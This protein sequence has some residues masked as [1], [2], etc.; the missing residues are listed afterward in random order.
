MGLF[1]ND[2]SSTPTTCPALPSPINDAAPISGSLTFNAMAKY[3]AGI[4]AAVAVVL[5]LGLILLHATHFSRP[6]EQTKIIRIIALIPVYALVSFGVIFLGQNAIYL[7]PWL[8]A[9]E[10]ISIINFFALLRTLSMSTFAAVNSNSP[11][12]FDMEQS[13]PMH[14]AP[15]KPAQ[16]M[17]EE[18]PQSRVQRIRLFVLQ[19]FPV[20]FLV[21]AITDIMQSLG[22]YCLNSNSPHF[23]HL[24]VC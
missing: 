17:E 14:G 2:D 13:V 18:M 11:P 24:W 10:G 5:S 1:H 9:A 8:S 15:M 22:R 16:L 12:P 23:G 19:Y 7:S 4:A 6:A 3:I 21:A 20:A